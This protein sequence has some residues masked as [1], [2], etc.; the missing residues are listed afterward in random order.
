MPVAV[1]VYKRA[2]DVYALS[3]EEYWKAPGLFEETDVIAIGEPLVRAMGAFAA[4]R[5]SGGVDVRVTP[6]PRHSPAFIGQD[7]GSAF[8][9]NLDG[10]RHSRLRAV[11]ASPHLPTRASLGV[12]ES[13]HGGLRTATLARTHYY[14]LI[15]IVRSFEGN[16]HGS[17]TAWPQIAISQA[18]QFLHY[19]VIARG[20]KID[21][22][23]RTKSARSLLR[24]DHINLIR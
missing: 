20:V 21:V 19:R 6:A 4:P 12:R 22:V 16:D 23:G 1:N 15:L 5:R 10:A 17:K 9:F 13:C 18:E 3:Y 14:S 11:R 8:G 7:R 2:I 24:V